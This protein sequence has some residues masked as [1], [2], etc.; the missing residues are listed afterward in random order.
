MAAHVPMPPFGVVVGAVE[1]QAVPQAADLESR[2]LEA[3]PT[4]PYWLRQ[5]LVQASKQ[6]KR[7]LHP[8]ARI[9]SKFNWPVSRML[10]AQDSCHGEMTYTDSCSIYCTIDRLQRGI[11]RVEDLGDLPV[12]VDEAGRVWSLGTRR[13]MALLA[14]QAWHRDVDIEVRC[15]ICPSIN[16]WTSHEGGGLSIETDGEDEYWS[17]HYGRVL[18]W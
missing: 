7:D 4:P 17:R 14:V 10:F 18:W 13:L 2:L 8:L 12:F 16:R 3:S 5:H 9:G 15:V 1:G 6:V 11:D